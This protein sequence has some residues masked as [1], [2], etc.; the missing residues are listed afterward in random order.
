MSES[1]LDLQMEATLQHFC[2]ELACNGSSAL[3]ET[4]WSHILELNRLRQNLGPDIRQNLRNGSGEVHS[5]EAIPSG[6]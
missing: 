4:L 1:L 3:A 6:D 5:T 2:E